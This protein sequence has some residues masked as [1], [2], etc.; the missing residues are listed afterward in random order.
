MHT[1]YTTH[2]GTQCGMHTHCTTHCSTHYTHT[3]AHTHAHALHHT[4]SAVHTHAHTHMRSHTGSHAHR[5]MKQRSSIGQANGCILLHVHS[6][7]AEKQ[8]LNCSN[9]LQSGTHS[10]TNDAMSQRGRKVT[11]CTPVGMRASLGAT[12]QSV[13]W[14]ARRLRGL[15]HPSTGWPA[16]R[17]SAL[18]ARYG[19]A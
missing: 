5:H 10:G 13:C 2:C 16:P 17:R 11:P 3:R 15:S 1:C 19:V 6:H 4:A 8:S 7:S 12:A 9:L 18:P 14:G